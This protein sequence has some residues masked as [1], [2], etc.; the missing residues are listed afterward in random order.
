MKAQGL[1]GSKFGNFNGFT[2]AE[3]LITLGII[4]VVAA[5]ILP[6]VI[7]T[8]RNKEYAAAK[9]KIMHTI[10]EGTKMLV[11]QGEMRSA[12]S[13]E[14]F[15]ENQL[16][17]TIKIIQTCK[18]DNLRGCGIETRP[19]KIYDLSE[20]PTTMPTK[21]GDLAEGI[22]SSGNIDVNSTSYGFV[23]S[24]GYAVNL[25]YN[26]NCKTDDPDANHWGQDRVCVNIIYD[27]NGLGEPNQVGKDIGFVTML[28]PDESTQTVAPDVYNKN[29]TPSDFHHA[30]SA[31]KALDKSLS[32]PSRDELLSM[33]INS[34]MSGIAPGYYWSSSSATGELG[35][36][37]S[38]NSGYRY[39]GAMSDATGGV[40]CVRK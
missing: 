16:K 10:G 13:A 14:D 11:V 37:Q 23:M 32:V 21:F 40:R 19:N 3:V 34:K 8:T 35:W 31:C 17:R 9:K 1:K 15:V 22:N 26:P 2:M 36:R 38:F 28:Y 6:T 18:N 24:N 33:Y 5:M 12:S 29:A 27:T 4:G 30:D 7:N 20:N 25:F 39:R